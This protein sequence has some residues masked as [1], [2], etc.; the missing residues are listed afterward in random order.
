M[1]DFTKVQLELIP[2][3]IASLQ[4]SNADLSTKNDILTNIIIGI[5]VATVAYVI[6]KNY[7]KFI[8]SQNQQNDLKFTKPKS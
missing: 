3:S 5:A 2:P 8:E 7:D 6:Y 4:K 1:I